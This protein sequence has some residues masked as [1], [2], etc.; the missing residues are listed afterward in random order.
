MS[1]AAF[2][3]M[4]PAWAAD[5]S[6]VLIEKLGPVAEWLR[7]GHHDYCDGKCTVGTAPTDLPIY[8]SNPN[9]V[10]KESVFVNLMG[11][12]VR[13]S[14]FAE[15]ANSQH[16]R[17]L[18]LSNTNADDAACEKIGTC[19]NLYCLDL[20]WTNI[21]VEGLKQ[22]AKLEHL[23]ILKLRGVQ[24]TPAVAQTLA[25]MPVLDY[26]DV[27]STNSESVSNIFAVK[28][29]EN[30]RTLS[31]QAIDFTNFPRPRETPIWPKLYTVALDQSSNTT[32]F[33]DALHDVNSL[34]N[35]R[36]FQMNDDDIQRIK[37]FA[38]PHGITVFDEDY[39]N[40]Q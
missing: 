11:L 25:S 18:Y 17:N 35:I 31:I 21:S 1:A 4:Q 27:S 15:L 14:I 5:P 13:P 16:L 24:I 29:F 39:I 33:L 22:I 40:T 23:H 34:R 10:T 19:T 20:S 12:Y 26:L 30:L 7:G 9:R 6:F 38:T 32:A 37:A 2:F 3:V 36:A 8:L 28:G